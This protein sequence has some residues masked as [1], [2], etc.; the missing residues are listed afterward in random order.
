MTQHKKTVIIVVVIIAA[1]IL[2]FILKNNKLT[3]PQSQTQAPGGA[4][5]QTGGGMP[6]GT[7]LSPGSSLPAPQSL[8]AVV[9]QQTGTVVG[10]GAGGMVA[11]PA[12]PAVFAP[13]VT[14]AQVQGSAGSAAGAY[15]SSNN[16]P[17]GF[18]TWYNSLGPVN[19]AY[20]SGII[21]TMDP[22]DINFIDTVV[23]QNLWG[24]SQIEAQWN[25]FVAKYGLPKNGTFNAFSGGSTRRKRN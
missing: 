14:D 12:T 18:Q 20:M 9:S 19:Q 17:S 8:P 13:T 5:P 11:I 10:S 22:A 3:A 25:A 7:S 24:T 6:S 15:S 23:K 1:I 16:L 4:N 21:P 2:Y